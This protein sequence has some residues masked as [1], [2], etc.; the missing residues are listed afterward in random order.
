MKNIVIIDCGP[1]FSEVSQQFGCATDWIIKILQNKKCKFKCVKAYKAETISQ[2]EGD[3][4]IITGS[5]ESVYN[6]LDWMLDLEEK[7]RFIKNLRTL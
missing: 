6:E 1:S 5:P 7:I 2:E 3:A 4:W